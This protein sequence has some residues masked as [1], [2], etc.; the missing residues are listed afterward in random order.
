V[1]ASADRPWSYRLSG[2]YELPYQVSLS[3]TWMYQAGAPEDTA[4]QVTNQ[5]ITLPQG[6]QTVR[7]REFGDVRFPTVVQLDMSL[8]KA[9]RF[10]NRTIAPRIDIFN[11]TNESTI[12]AWVTQLGPTYHRPSTIQR[13]RLIKV[14]LNI[15]FYRLPATS[16][17]LAS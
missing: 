2:V 5:T 11:A 9:F 8:R 12:S 17:S 13:A 14:G 10:G 15:E 16:Y 7:V 1:L 3:G 4:V 6:N